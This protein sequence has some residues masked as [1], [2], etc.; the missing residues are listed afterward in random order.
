MTS[1]ERVKAVLEGNVPDR[2]PIDCG[3]TEDTGI[4]GVAYNA[5]KQ[6]LGIEG[7]FDPVFVDDQ[8]FF[9]THEQNVHEK[10]LPRQNQYMTD[11]ISG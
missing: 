4:H 8:G 9:R 6:H 10:Y 11:P 1:R 7:T 2:V 3:G 5:L